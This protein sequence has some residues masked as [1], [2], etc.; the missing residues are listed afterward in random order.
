MQGF[1]PG[2][3]P[4]PE[5]QIT[6][7]GAASPPRHPVT[8]P[9]PEKHQFAMPKCAKMHNPSTLPAVAASSCV[10]IVERRSSCAGWRCG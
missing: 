10:T 8:I 6:P 7:D 3:F 1:P 9:S 4:L 2:H 5:I